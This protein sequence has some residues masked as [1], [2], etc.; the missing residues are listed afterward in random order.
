MSLAR[1]LS[2]FWR[3]ETGIFLCLWLYLLAAGQTKLLR[4]PGTFWHTVLGQKMLTT[5]QLVRGDPFCFAEGRDKENWIPHQWLGECLMALLHRI[6]GLDTLVLATATI[7][8]AVYAW[9][10]HRLIRHGLHWSLAAL[11][12]FVVVGASASHFHARPHLATIA[13]LGLTFARLCD[14]EAGRVSLAGLFWLVPLYVLWTSLHGGMLG[15]LA[16]MVAA[17]GGWGVYRALGWESPV[18]G[19]RTAAALAGLIVACGLTAFVNPYGTDL[20][21]VW[22]SILDADALGKIIQEHAPLNPAKL[23]G[24]AVLVLAGVYAAVLLNLKRWPRVTWLL[25]VLWLYQACLHIRHAPL[26]GITAGLALAEMLPQT[27]WAE[28]R[29]RSGSD[30]FVP[31]PKDAAPFGWRP[32]L[33]PAAAVLG[34]LWLQAN[35]VEAPLV[36]HGWVRLDPEVW[37]VEVQPQ[38]EELRQTAPDGTPIFNDLGFGGYLVYYAP[39]LRIF[40]D[41]RC[42]LHDPKW[43]KEYVAADRDADAAKVAEWQKQW[44]FEWALVR[45]GSGFDEVFRESELRR[46]NLNASATIILQ[47]QP[48]VAAGCASYFLT[49]RSPHWSVVRRTETATLYRRKATRG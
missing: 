42:E 8:A 19:W 7:L 17:L 4:D 13:F 37:P 32:L 11:L 46:N 39:N 18:A 41:D 49:A 9:L 30:L 27:R 28:G 25:P 44:P 12:V 22:F 47:N 16:T 35:R 10:A 23:D 14:F 15:G 20:P 36:G 3:P 43:L 45:T 40:V 38:L 48:L 26:F 31:P 6:D 33:L 5:G 1:A 2:R 34:S 24:L 29:V 21:R